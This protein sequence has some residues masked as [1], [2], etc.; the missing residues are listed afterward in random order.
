MNLQILFAVAM[1][2]C[3]IGMGL[4][5]WLMM[6]NSRDQSAPS[7]SQKLASAAERLAAL[8]A[9]RAVL[10]AEIAESARIAE[11]EGKRDAL[12]GAS[13]PASDPASPAAVQNTN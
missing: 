10:E 4:M 1:L 12:R 13:T 5:M 3:P 2:A 11:L 6:R 7:G 9:Q 8:R